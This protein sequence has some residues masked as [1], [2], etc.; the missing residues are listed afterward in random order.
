MM[1]EVFYLISYTHYLLFSFTYGSMHKLNFNCRQYL[2]YG[3][4]SLFNDIILSQQ[5]PTVKKDIVPEHLPKKSAYKNNFIYF[6]ARLALSSF[7]LLFNSTL[8]S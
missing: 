4:W 2:N 6:L 1:V 7:N 5:K 3:G 8:H